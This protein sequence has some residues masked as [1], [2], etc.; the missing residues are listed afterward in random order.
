MSWMPIVAMIFVV[1][2]LA[3]LFVGIGSFAKGGE[4]NKKHGNKLMRFRVGFQLAALVL[5]AL[6]FFLSDRG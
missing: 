5:I 1:L 2:T 4:F 6:M 3:V